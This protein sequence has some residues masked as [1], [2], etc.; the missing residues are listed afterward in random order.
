[1]IKDFK[2]QIKMWKKDLGVERS[3]KILMKKK[4]DNLVEKIEMEKVQKESKSSQSDAN[5]DIP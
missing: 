5:P 1:M 3:E 4:L 2:S